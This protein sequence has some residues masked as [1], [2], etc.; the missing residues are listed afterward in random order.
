[1][2]KKHRELLRRNRVALV[3]DLDAK[4]LLN[5]IWQEGIL[6]DNDVE[7]IKVESTRNARAE[8]LLDIIPRRGPKAFDV[9]CEALNGNEGQRHL[10]F[11]LKA[12]IVADSSGKNDFE[13]G[14]GRVS[15]KFVCV[16]PVFLY[17]YTPTLT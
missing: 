2:E 10:V 16:Q 13:S 4:Q 12:N 11:L 3:Q 15:P 6:T 8:K 17:L 14:K 9:F 5:Y 7:T 1:M